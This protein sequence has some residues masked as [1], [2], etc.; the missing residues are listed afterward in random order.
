MWMLIW[1]C[2][3]EPVYVVV[4]SQDATG[5]PAVGQPSKATHMRTE[6]GK[7]LTKGTG[8]ISE[9]CAPFAKLRLEIM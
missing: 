2:G 7:A 9:Q 3:Y 4:R 8:H 5:P 6:H 1:D